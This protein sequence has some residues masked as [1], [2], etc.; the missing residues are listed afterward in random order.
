MLTWKR[1]WF[2]Y[3]CQVRHGAG[4]H[5]KAHEWQKHFFLVID[6]KENKVAHIAEPIK[7][8]SHVHRSKTLLGFNTLVK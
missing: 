2:G 6:P 8:P 4:Q 1:I 3:G 7:Y 5:I